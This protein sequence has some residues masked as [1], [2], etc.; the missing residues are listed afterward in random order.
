MRK[1]SGFSRKLRIGKLHDDNHRIERTFRFR[2]FQE[3][4]GF[5]RN[6]GDLAEAESHHPDISFGWGYATISL[7]TKKVKGLHENDF[8]MACKIDRLFGRPDGLPDRK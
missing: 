2:N 1:R 7:R 5:V 3:A 4:L 8:I 6:V